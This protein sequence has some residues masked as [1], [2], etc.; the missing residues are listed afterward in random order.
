M[1]QYLMVFIQF[2]GIMAEFDILIYN[3]EE[4]IFLFKVKELY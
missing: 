1:L 4:I 2:Y 3:S